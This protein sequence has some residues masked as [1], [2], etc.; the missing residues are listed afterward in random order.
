[1]VAPILR[2]AFELL[3]DKGRTAI[4]A[5]LKPKVEL[6]R[7][8]ALLEAMQRDAVALA[9]VKEGVTSPPAD[10]AD[11]RALTTRLLKAYRIADADGGGGGDS[12][13]TEYFRTLHGDLHR[14]FMADDVDGAGAVLSDPGATNL[15][16]GFDQL[17]KDH[18]AFAASAR[19]RSANARATA[20]SIVRLAEML[21]V[22]RHPNAEAI[23]NGY[24]RRE[25]VDAASC[26]PL[27]DAAIG[28]PV[29]VPAPFPGDHGLAT[30]RGVVSYRTPQ[31]VYQAWRIR[32]MT[33]GIRKPKVL[34]IGGGLGRTAYYANRLG[35]ADYTIVDLPMTSLAQGAYLGRALGEDR[36]ALLGEKHRDAASRVK[37]IS[38]KSFME[39]KSRYDL[40]VNVDSLTEMSRDVAGD[41]MGQILKRADAFLSINHE[42]NPFTVRELLDECEVPRPVTRMVCHMRN[43]YV[44]EFADLRKGP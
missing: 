28:I 23:A 22:R 16:Y 13:W 38:Q 8:V 24:V 4:R 7:I 21:G 11:R 40:I 27:I 20:D 12:A 37:L 43:G 15:F 36:V 32:Q 14:M 41:Y 2:R 5:A 30:V 18:L 9:E 17:A 31:A 44:E 42:S 34:E 33:C 35:I 26:L 6:G 29:D 3:P 1:M 10:G 19:W 39:G 25:T